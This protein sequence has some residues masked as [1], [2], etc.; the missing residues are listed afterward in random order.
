MRF[1]WLLLFVLLTG[2]TRAQQG[3]LSGTVL[4]ESGK[5]LENATVQLTAFTDSTNRH[6]I[7][8]DKSGSF[9]FPSLSFGYY[10]LR[11]SY[12]GLQPLLI[13]SLQFRVER[14]IISLGD[15]V[16]K[17][18]Q[19]SNLDEIIIYAEK[20]LVQSKDGNITYNAGESPL[21]QGS[22]ASDLLTQVPLVSK[23]PNGKVLVRGK[24]PRILI[25]DKPVE[26]NLQQLQDLLESLPGSSI[27]KN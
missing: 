11:I 27:E 9:S 16:L 14:P 2:Y 21:S 18:R 15:L 3:D 13:D 20:P 7:T 4:D 10:R 12:V 8:T 19:S 22:N 23:D 26:L 5:A 25:D 6:S 1:C 17:P 24:E